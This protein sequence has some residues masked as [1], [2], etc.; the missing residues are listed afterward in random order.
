MKKEFRSF[1]KALSW[2]SDHARN[3]QDFKLLKE[4]LETHH[5]FTGE[6]F[7]YTNL[8]CSSNGGKI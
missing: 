8:A 6:Y 5:Y 4:Q 7:L 3:E 2:I 1:V